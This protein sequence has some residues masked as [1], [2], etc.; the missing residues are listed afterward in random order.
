[1]TGDL[2]TRTAVRRAQ[3]R[4]ALR[5]FQRGALQ[6]VQH[7]EEILQLAREHAGDSAQSILQS[8][9]IHRADVAGLGLPYHFANAADVAARSAGIKSKKVFQ[10]HRA[11]HQMANVAKHDHFDV[12]DPPPPMEEWPLPLP[13]PVEHLEIENKIIL[14]GTFACA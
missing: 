4:H 6:R 12:L 8:I 14:E 2:M 3:R 9:A 13:P 5:C 10:A 11:A 1:M 7:M